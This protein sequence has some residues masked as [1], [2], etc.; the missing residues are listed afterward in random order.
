MRTL[1]ILT[2]LLGLTGCLVIEDDGYRHHYVGNPIPGRNPGG[3]P[4]Y[5][6]DCRWLRSFNCW[7]LAVAEMEA[8]APQTYAGPYGGVVADYGYSCWYPDGSAVLFEEPV[9]A[10]NSAY[11]RWSFT[12][13]DPAGNTCGWFVETDTS[14]TMGTASGVVKLVMDAGGISVICQ[15]GSEWYH[16]DP[17]YLTRCPGG[18]LEAPGYWVEP[19]ARSAT[20]GLFGETQPT[21]FSCGW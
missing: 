5:E 18:D 15:D 4:V 6:L 11:Y 14:V 8:C 16:P 20:L 2:A 9:Y 13:E 17:Y 10:Q 12:M 19:G 7:D 1:A 21:L 3:P